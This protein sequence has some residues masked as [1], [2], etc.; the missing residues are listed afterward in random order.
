MAATNSC[1]LPKMPRRRRCCVSL[2]NQLSRNPVDGSL[3]P[4]SQ[5]AA[6][7][8]APASRSES[9]LRHGKCC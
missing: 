7:D 5:I 8:Y 2:L 4:A 3:P 6:G 9:E 1:T